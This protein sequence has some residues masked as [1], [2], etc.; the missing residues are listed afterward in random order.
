MRSHTTMSMALLASGAAFAFTSRCPAPD[1]RAYMEEYEHPEWAAHGYERLVTYRLYATDTGPEGVFAAFGTPESPFYV[2]S[3]TNEFVN[4]FGELTAPLDLTSAGIWANQWDSYVTINATMAGGDET[5]LS[6]NFAAATNNLRSNFSTDNAGW[7]V[8]PDAEQHLPDE[9]GRVL[10]AQFTVEPTNCGPE[11]PD[12]WGVV[13]YF[14]GDLEQRDQ[15]L[16]A[17]GNVKSIDFPCSDLDGDG[18]VN[19]PD[20]VEVVMQWGDEV[21]CK[22]DLSR[23]GVVDFADILVIIR[24]WGPCIVIQGP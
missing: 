5:Q 16:F 1:F 13:N 6:P 22:P 20:I 21:P 18:F 7:L 8:T 23:N 2:R 4:V 9:F 12:V 10:L 17:A 14:T 19:F 11:L 24:D 3:G 15:V